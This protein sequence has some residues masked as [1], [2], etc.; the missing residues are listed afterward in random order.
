VRIAG[1]WALEPPLNF[2]RTLYHLDWMEPVVRGPA[3]APGDYYVF[4]S[5]DA[6]VVSKL[7]LTVIYTDPL[8][9]TLLAR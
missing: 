6:D 7:H 5:S 1:S 4:W 2:Y 9:G 8:S 3:D